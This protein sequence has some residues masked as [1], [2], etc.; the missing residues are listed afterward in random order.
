[1]FWKVETYIEKKNLTNKKSI[2]KKKKK[3]NKLGKENGFVSFLGT[4]DNTHLSIWLGKEKS[5]LEFFFYRK[6]CYK[7]T[8]LLDTVLRERETWTP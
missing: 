8:N 4:R 2:R 1:M 7:R 5:P 6:E 3:K